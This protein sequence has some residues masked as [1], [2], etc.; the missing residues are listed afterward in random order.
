[1]FGI[2]DLVVLTVYAD[3]V[4]SVSTA[5]YTV[6]GLY[7]SVPCYMDHLEEVVIL[8]WCRQEDT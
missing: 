2:D 1:M 5:Y 4:S 7:M 3:I 8:V 6:S